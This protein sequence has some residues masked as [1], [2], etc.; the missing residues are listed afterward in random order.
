VTIYVKTKEAFARALRLTKTKAALAVCAAW[1]VKTEG[2][3]SIVTEFLI[4]V[5]TSLSYAQLKLVKTF[6]FN[7]L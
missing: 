6:G 3:K 4:M 1:L 5:L 7:K 2:F